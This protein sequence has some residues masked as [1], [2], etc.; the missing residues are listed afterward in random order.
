MFLC[1]EKMENAS[2]H[3]N[4]CKRPLKPFQNVG[5]KIHMEFFI[6]VNAISYQAIPVKCG[7][8]ENKDQWSRRDGHHHSA[9]RFSA[10]VT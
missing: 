6:K 4:L 8:F 1:G 9:R 5:G 3:K 10:T 2:L 7:R